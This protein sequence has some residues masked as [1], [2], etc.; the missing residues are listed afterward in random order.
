MRM[1]VAA[2]GAP[3]LAQP[4]QPQNTGNISAVEQAGSTSDLMGAEFNA[5]DTQTGSSFSET[6]Q[7][8]VTSRA[9][10]NDEDARQ[11]LAT[12][13]RYKEGKSNLEN[14]VIEDERWYQLRHWEY[15]RNRKAD[16]CNP[17]PQP[18]SAWLFNSIANKHADAMDN[19]PEPN[20]L[21]REQ[22]DEADAKTLSA[23][24][25]VVLER[26][27]FEDVYSK[28]WWEKLKHG[29][30]VYGVF[31]DNTLANGLGDIAVKDI[32]LLNIFWEPGQMDIQ[33][34]RNV[35][36]VTLQ[37]EDIVA[38]Q[39]PDL[40]DQLRSGNVIT[41]EYRFDDTV[42]TSGKTP[43][44]DWYYKVSDGG[45]KVLLHYAKIIGG[46]LVFASQNEPEYAETGWYAHGQYPFVMDTLFPVKGTPCG[47]GYVQICKDPQL[48]IDKLSANIMESSM[49]GSKIRF[50]ASDDTNVNEE[51]I[52]D[53]NKPIIHVAGRIDETKMKQLDV[54]DISPIYLNVM[55]Q[56][57]DE[58][59]ETSS[60][61]DVSNGGST[62]G[63]TAAAAI[64]ALQEAG[65]KMSRDMIQGSYRKYQQIGYLCLELIRQFYDEARTFRI[66]GEDGSYQFE[67][68]SNQG[69]V[70]QQTGVD[71]MG[72]PMYRL[73]V[74][75]IKIKPQKRSPFAREAQNQR[76]LELYS[77]GFFAPENAQPALNCLEMMDFEGIEKVRKQVAEG[78]TLMNQLQQMNMMLQDAMGKIAMLTGAGM[79][80]QQMAAE[81]GEPQQSGGARPGGAGRNVA[82]DMLD[83]QSQN[84]M[85]QYG[86]RLAAN[87]TPDVTNQSGGVM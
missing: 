62:G 47:F 60:N 33:K 61:R 26:N 79:A 52:K 85:T 23:I 83:D 15:L 82:R 66:T 7:G 13:K 74:F 41:A 78:Q 6:G 9:R 77:A 19:Y 43:V 55:Q 28:N 57:I 87:S 50:L 27:D 5:V 45:G 44:V 42:D 53:W 39:Y 80:R 84:A 71:A 68:Y 65:N 18:T 14:R 10:L 64:A 37:D 69:I 46:H 59:K 31:W 34:S 72:Q 21:P 48:Y 35:F 1:A 22:N 86:K 12:L 36:V 8:L 81:G 20:V 56:K 38:S 73:P 2:A 24:L 70:P 58:L 25:P 49:A 67:D 30:A 76:A 75:D 3:E 11:A 17:T 4:Q 16:P 63:A 51:E 29:T 40:K 54:H 32:D